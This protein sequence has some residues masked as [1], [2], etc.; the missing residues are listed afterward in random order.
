MVQAGLHTEPRPSA[1]SA[2]CLQELSGPLQSR[3]WEQIK[4]QGGNQGTTS[5]MQKQYKEELKKVSNQQYR[6]THCC[7]TGRER[8][9][10]H[11]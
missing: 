4:I 5:L 3:D 11:Q 8:T 1:P 10:I 2:P 6:S 7:F 9:E